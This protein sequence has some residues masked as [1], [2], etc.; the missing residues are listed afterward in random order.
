[1]QVVF[2]IVLGLL[3]LYVIFNWLQGI[4]AILMWPSCLL[5]LPGAMI[6]GPDETAHLHPRRRKVGVLLAFLGAL[7]GVFLLVGFVVA[8]TY[9]LRSQFAF[10]PSWLLWPEMLLMVFGLYWTVARGMSRREPGEEPPEKVGAATCTL[11]AYAAPIAFLLFAFVPSIVH[12]PLHSFPY[13]QYMP[14]EKEV[15]Q[16]YI[17]E[18]RSLWMRSESESAVAQT[19]T[20]EVIDLMRNDQKRGMDAFIAYMEKGLPPYGRY[21]SDL[22]V[23]KPPR[24]LREF[25]EKH[26][27]LRAKTMEIMQNGVSRMKSTR[28]GSIVKEVESQITKLGEKTLPEMILLL[29]SVG[30]NEDQFFP[31]TPETGTGTG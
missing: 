3:G 9:F 4:L 25:H 22:S 10:Y 30:Y 1:M 23:L 2:Q 11:A 28:D 14:T 8:F 15:E 13:M 6:A 5:W 17:N 16:S 19:N 26:L 29:R 12:G 7:V 24:R 27:S 18:L 21:L 20:Q 31:E